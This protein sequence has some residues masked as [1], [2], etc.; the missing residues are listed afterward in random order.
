MKILSIA[1]TPLAQIRYLNVSPGRK[2]VAEGLPILLG[3]VDKLPAGLQALVAA[4]DLQGYE[5][6]NYKHGDC[7]R[8]L[9]EVVAESI[10]DLA[11]KGSLPPHGNVGILL[12]GDMYARPQMDRRGGSGDV[13]PVWRAFRDAGFRFVC[14]VAGNHDLFSDNSS[15]A[16]FINFTSE[17][18]IIML[19]GQVAVIDT[20]RIGGV[21]GVVGNPAKPWRR[22]EQTM[23][24]VTEDLLLEN[25]DVLICHDGPGFPQSGLTGWESIASALESINKPLLVIR[26]HSHWDVPMVEMECGTQILNVDGRVVVLTV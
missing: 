13:R 14:G 1:D 10:S 3:K 23:V 24:R 19:D 6:A 18:G 17:E 12:A 9:G 16:D 5:Y 2:V 21:S 20:L 26:G 7:P 4:A 22:D 15:R 11:S 25:L 8:L